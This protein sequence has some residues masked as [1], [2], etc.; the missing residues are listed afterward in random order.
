M[1]RSTLLCNPLEGAEKISSHYIGTD[2]AHSIADFQ[3]CLLE[4]RLNQPRHMYTSRCASRFS[5]F[6]G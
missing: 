2:D 1:R 5:G 4:R 6:Q 3:A